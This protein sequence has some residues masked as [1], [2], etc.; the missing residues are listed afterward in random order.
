M[1]QGVIDRHFAPFTMYEESPALRGVKSS[2]NVHDE[3]AAEG[4]AASLG[5]ILCVCS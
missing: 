5:C 2:R 4:S 3:D 1:E